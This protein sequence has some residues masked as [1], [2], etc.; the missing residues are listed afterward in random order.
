MQTKAQNINHKEY[1]EVAEFK[2]LGLPVTYAN[3]CGKDTPSRI[4]A[5]NQ[6]YQAL[7]KSMKSRSI[8]KKNEKYSVFGKSLCT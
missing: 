3:D 1:Q 7:L 5:G 6:S 4:T 2:C 8:F